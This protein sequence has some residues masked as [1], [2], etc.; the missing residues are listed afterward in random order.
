MVVLWT[1]CDAWLHFPLVV[2]R[3]ASFVQPHTS[4]FF[5][6]RG[7]AGKDPEVLKLMMRTIVFHSGVIL[8]GRCK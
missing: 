4:I 1:R 2:T 6:C 5:W 8:R 3:L 7:G